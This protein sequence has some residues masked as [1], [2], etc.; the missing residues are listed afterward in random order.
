MTTKA[1][2]ALIYASWGWH[3][4]PVVPNGKVPATLHGVKD[5]TTDP[6]QIARWW[7]QNPDFNIGIAAGER[8]VSLPKP[9][10]EVFHGRVDVSPA[11]GGLAVGPAVPESQHHESAG[12]GPARSA[13]AHPAGEPGGQPHRQRAVEPEGTAVHGQDCLRTCASAT[14]EFHGFVDATHVQSPCGGSIVT[15]C[16]GA[17]NAQG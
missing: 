16:A 7:A 8:S 13:Q 4:L 2:A 11:T 5:A 3:V 9:G 17:G 15:A 12:D 6:E 10:G 1:E 14:K